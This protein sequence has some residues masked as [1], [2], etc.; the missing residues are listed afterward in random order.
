MDHGS[1]EKKSGD[2]SIGALTSLAMQWRNEGMDSTQ[3]EASLAEHLRSAGLRED[4][5]SSKLALVS[6]E[7]NARTTLGPPPDHVTTQQTIWELQQTICLLQRQIAGLNEQAQST[8]ETG[9]APLRTRHTRIP[10]PEMF[11]GVRSDYRRF[12]IQMK[13]KME[14]DRERIGKPTGYMFN[15]LKDNASTLAISWITREENGTEE[16]FWRFLDQQYADLLL[17]EKARNKLQTFKQKRQPLQAFNAEFMRLAYDANEES[18]HPSLKS[19]YLAAIRSDLQDR[20]ISVEVPREWDIHALMDRVAQIEEN[21]YR[22]R[23]SSGTRCRKGSPTGRDE[24]DW[25]PTRVNTSRNRGPSQQS[26]QTRAQWAS[27]SER[28]RRQEKGLCLRCG[29]EG[30]FVRGCRYLPATRPVR[31]NPATLKENSAEESEGTASEN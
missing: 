12:K 31:T 24:M 3:I 15:R 29:E 8:P 22:S 7:L 13:H 26:K 1:R 30:H 14:H 27:V 2:T 23:I 6:S 25:E 4:E 28:S 10:D 16:D 5:I 20:M 11:S 21:L 9:N 18:N 19:R 17:D